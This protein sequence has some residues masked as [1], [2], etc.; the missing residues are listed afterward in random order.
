MWTYFGV[1]VKTVIS[2]E[3]FDENEKNQKNTKLFWIEI[4]LNLNFIDW[5]V[6]T[7]IRMSLL[8]AYVAQQPIT[9]TNAMTNDIRVKDIDTLI[10]LI[11]MSR[12]IGS[13]DRAET[14][15]ETNSNAIAITFE[16]KNI[17]GINWL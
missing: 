17:I 14:P 3:N 1:E 2:G 9:D 16:I 12:S 7:R 15:L 6:I 4:V 11:W 8:F 10:A 5:T 13:R